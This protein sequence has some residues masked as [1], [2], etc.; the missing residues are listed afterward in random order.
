[1]MAGHAESANRLAMLWCRVT[2][3]G[4]PA[5][6][7]IT[8][9]ETAHDP[10]ARHFGNNRGGGN[11]EAQRIALDDGL[12]RAGEGRGDIAVDERSIGADPEDGN[13]ASHCQQG[14]AQDVDAVYFGHAGRSN[15]DA[16]GA[17]ARATSKGPVAGLALLDGQHLR[18]VEPLAQAF[19][20]AAEVENHGGRDDRPGQ[21]PAPGLIDTANQPCAT[22]FDLK[23]RHRL[24]PDRLVPQGRPTEQ[25]RTRRD[26]GARQE[27][28]YFFSVPGLALPLMRLDPLSR[29]RP[30]F[31]VLVVTAGLFLLA[32]SSA[33]A[34]NLLGMHEVT[35]QFATQDGKPLANSEVRV[36]SPGDPK[37]PVLTGRTD[38]EGKFA[39]EADRDGFWSAEASGADQVARVMIRVGGESQAQTWLSP[40]L[41]IG[42]L[43]ILA[44]IAIWYR[45]LRARARRPRS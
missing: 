32:L 38:A 6:T 34:F 5:I 37:N 19:R 2:D 40:F 23:I 15:P 10:V 13:G 25:E 33:L 41:V 16:G 43:G 9:C 31:L 42:V 44:A 36:F 26:A 3:I 24:S 18:I 4:I 7:R 30:A 8:R 1:M 20:K 35:V 17:P 39:F 28:R 22:A 45:L 11:R 21:R 14:R 12:Y 27:Q 29:L